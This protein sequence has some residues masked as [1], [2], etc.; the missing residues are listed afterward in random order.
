MNK[1]HV[2]HPSLDKIQDRIDAIV[3]FIPGCDSQLLM[4]RVLMKLITA[5]LNERMREVLREHDFHPV[6]FTALI[7][8]INSNGAPLNPSELSDMTGES[9]ANTTR[10]CDELVASGYLERHANPED[11]RRV[12]LFLAPAGEEAARTLL[13]AV[14]SRV[15]A[16]LKSLTATDR[17]GLEATLKHLLATLEVDKDGAC[18]AASR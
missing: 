14:H 2:S 11:R 5:D 1:Q 17:D 7:M 6:S 8:L 4:L 18:P 13:P 15:L 12:D 3:N 9:R 10:I 16:P